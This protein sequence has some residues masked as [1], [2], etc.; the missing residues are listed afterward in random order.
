[1]KK[2]R[3]FFLFQLE[4]SASRCILNDHS[5]TNGGRGYEKNTFNDRNTGYGIL[6]VALAV[7]TNGCSCFFPCEKTESE[8][9]AVPVKA[10]QEKKACPK[11]Q[12]VKK[13]TE[14]T[15]KKTG[16]AVK[17]TVEA[18]KEEIKKAVETKAPD[19]APT[20]SSVWTLELNTLKGAEKSWKNQQRILR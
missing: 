14:K 18:K 9:P 5:I 19:I 16:E 8:T 4:L 12:T 17:K 7:F 13:E 15:V 1:M 6:S 10:E 3:R 20:V 11:Q 2:V